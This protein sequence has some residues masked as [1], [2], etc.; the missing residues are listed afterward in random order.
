MHRFINQDPIGIWG[1]A[2]NLGNGFAYVAGMVVEAKDPTGL[3]GFTTATYWPSFD[4]QRKKGVPLEDAHAIS[5][6]VADGAS[7]YVDGSDCY[8]GLVSVAALLKMAHESINSKGSD[9]FGNYDKDSLKL[10]V[11]AS[12][13]TDCDGTIKIQIIYDNNS[14]MDVTINSDKS[15]SLIERDSTGRIVNFVIFDSE[16]NIV[17]QWIWDPNRDG[18][19]KGGYV[20]IVGIPSDPNDSGDAIQNYLRNQLLN[21]MMKNKNGNNNDDKEPIIHWKNE[22]GSIQFIHNPYYRQKDPTKRIIMGKTPNG[23]VITR[24]PIGPTKE[25]LDEEKARI[26]FLQRMNKLISDDGK[27]DPVYNMER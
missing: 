14:S 16:G 9:T 2:N 10:P 23:P 12:K 6:K 3:E 27:I 25:E 22:D 11:F 5:E 21:K 26:E 19:G 20:K 13:N 24:N 18:P 7:L 8:E 1:D 15:G 4:A 17:E